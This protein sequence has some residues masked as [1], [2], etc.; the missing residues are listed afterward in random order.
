MSKQVFL[1]FTIFYCTVAMFIFFRS[2]PKRFKT[3]PGY[4][5]QRC[6]LDVRVDDEKNIVQET[7]TLCGIVS[8]LADGRRY[9]AGEYVPIMT[10]EEARIWE[11]R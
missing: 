6:I 3:P 10:S 4:F 1:S 5:F 8:N 11:G 2:E 7:D 9:G